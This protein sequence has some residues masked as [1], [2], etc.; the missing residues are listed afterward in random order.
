[1]NLFKKLLII[2]MSS[3]LAL[4]A[5]A[6]DRLTTN[7]AQSLIPATINTTQVSDSLTASK[8]EGKWG[9]TNTAGKMVVPYK[10]DA[11][12]DFSEGLA[13]VVHNDMYGAIDTTG[14]TVVPFKYDHLGNFSD[15][16]ALF[17]KDGNGLIGFVD[18]KGHETIEPVWD[19]G[20]GFSEGLAAVGIT[21]DGGYRWG[22]IDTTGKVAI[23]LQYDAVYIED[24]GEPPQISG[25]YFKDGVVK[26]YKIEEQ[27]KTIVI[28]KL[29][30]VVSEQQ[31]SK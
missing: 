12:S 29:G 14:R 4:A 26:V 9:Y 7:K 1:M 16:M 19:M 5:C 10:Y 3:I 13:V 2:S 11:V 25:G 31:I 27:I 30:N 6:E 28:D 21:L 17:T 18:S 24:D 8:K 23:K 22:F 20:L 15:G